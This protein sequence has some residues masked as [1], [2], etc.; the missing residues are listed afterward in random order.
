MK[1]RPD[2]AEKHLPHPDRSR[3]TTAAHADFPE[4]LTGISVSRSGVSVS[5]PENLISAHGCPVGE[6]EKNGRCIHPEKIPHP[7]LRTDWNANEAHFRSSPS[8]RAR[9]VV[10][11]VKDVPKRV[12]FSAARAAT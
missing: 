6:T 10:R 7:Y 11:L 5:R 1:Q 3:Q 8:L 2:E 12:Y 9:S 4:R